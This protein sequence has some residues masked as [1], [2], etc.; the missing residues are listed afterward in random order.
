MGSLAATGTQINV[1]D[2][3]DLLAHDE[4]LLLPAH[5]H[6]LQPI[7]S[8]LR[9]LS[10]R[11][12][13]ALSRAYKRNQL[14]HLEANFSLKLKQSIT[15]ARN[16]KGKTGQDTAYP[17]QLMPFLS[18]ATPGLET[19]SVSLPGTK[20]LSTLCRQN[21]GLAL[22]DARFDYMAHHLHFTRLC[23]LSLSHIKSTVDS[24]TRFLR[25]AR[26]T[27]QELNLQCLCWTNH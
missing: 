21:P 10:I 14:E 11:I 12:C 6:L 22:A 8:H 18:L 9:H 4:L 1:L 27:L 16:Q 7:L 24:F 15:T 25:S 3:G 13:S 19:F 20:S 26:P 2:A 5:E 17:D 23:V